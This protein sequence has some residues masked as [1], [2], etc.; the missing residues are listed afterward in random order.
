[1][2]GPVYGYPAE[3]PAEAREKLTSL[4]LLGEPRLLNDVRVLQAFIAGI[5]HAPPSRL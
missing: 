5:R 1:M 4:S 2:L 3:A